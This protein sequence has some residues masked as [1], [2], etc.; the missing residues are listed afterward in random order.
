MAF[1]TSAVACA[2]A[3]AWVHRAIAAAVDVTVDETPLDR[4][5]VT[6]YM[7]A[8]TSFAICWPAPGEAGVRP[9]AHAMVRPADAAQE[10]ARLFLRDDGW[11]PISVTH[12]GVTAEA[13]A[14]GMGRVVV[15]R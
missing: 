9:L 10:D 1:C 13:A 15:V 12:G 14:G 6:E 7:V 4:R 11:S 3:S 8:C 2:T 5:P